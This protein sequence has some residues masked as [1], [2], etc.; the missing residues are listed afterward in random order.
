MPDV[1]PGIVMHSMTYTLYPGFQVPTQS[2]D[3]LP[4]GCP[5]TTLEF[6]QLSRMC[7]GCVSRAVDHMNS[8]T[9]RLTQPWHL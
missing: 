1:T 5:P 9:S 6:A 7:H 8:P 3:R 4:C 2:T